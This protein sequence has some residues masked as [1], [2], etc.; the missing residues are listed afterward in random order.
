MRAQK[1]YQKREKIVA[2]KGHCP[3]KENKQEKRSDTKKLATMTELYRINKER[4]RAIDIDAIRQKIR[5]TKGTK[6]VGSWRTSH[7]IRA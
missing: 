6:Q 3:G 5:I 1:K 2:N 7:R 4:E